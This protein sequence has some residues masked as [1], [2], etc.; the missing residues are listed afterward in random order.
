MTSTERGWSSDS[1]V[2]PTGSAWDL[3]VV[4]G[5][6]AGIVAAKTAAGFGATVLMV[7]KDRTGGD[8][9]WTG[10]VPSKALLAA[11]HAAESA[12]SASQFGIDVERV[13]VDFARVLHHVAESISTIEPLDSPAAMRT[14]GIQVIRASVRMTGKDS[15]DID[16]Q[17]VR[18]RQAVI[19]TGSSPTQ[20]NIPGLS[21]A[22]PLTSDT[23]WSLTQLPERLLVVG[24]GSIGCELG[25]AFARLGSKVTIVE[26]APRLLPAE[27]PDAARLVFDALSVDGVDI[28]TGVSLNRFDI[29]AGQHHAELG[30]S[31]HVQFDR[32]LVATGRRPRTDN[33]GLTA[34]AVDL[35]EKGYVRV[36]S[37]LRTTN[38]RIW[39]AGDVT[40]HPQFTHTAGV[41]GSLA[42]ANAILGL[43]RKV[44]LATIPRVTY[45]QPEVASF[46]VGSSGV[47]DS[48][49]SVKTISHDDVD[50][51]VTEQQGHGFS[52]L[53]LDHRGRIVGATLVGPRAGES[54]AE[55]VLAARHGLR[56][57]DLAGTMHAYPTYA[58][59][60]WKASVARV[61]DDL[62]GRFVSRLIMALLVI[63]RLFSAR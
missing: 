27:D 16:G 18:F 32:V 30:D 36:D 59:G 1:P 22:D 10:C 4:G 38:R 52:R 17:T 8:C 42:A 57:R 62:G 21:D 39:A 51:A 23:I 12:R 6:T 55:A 60:L 15:A 56:A 33:L 2:P 63:R 46:G 50:R 35:D 24:G 37:R 7:E 43:R 40:G 26:A 44:D 45:T 25:Q 58:D 5:G 14:A 41:H 9:L 48:D 19:A 61:Q 29:Q 28:R 53:V 20:P 47:R 54:L 3:L 31:T 34:S 49:L 13:N 11:A